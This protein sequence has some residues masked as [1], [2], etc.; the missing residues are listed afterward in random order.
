VLRVFLG[1]V[2]DESDEQLVLIEAD[3]DDMTPAALSAA[4]ERLRAEGARDVS[5]LPLQMKKSR[6]AMRLSVLVDTGLLARLSGAV[7]LHT[8]SIGARYRAVGRSVLAR[9]I[10]VVETVAGPIR[11]K[12]VARP[13]G[14]ESAEPEFEDVAAAAAATGRTFADLREEALAAWRRG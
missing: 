1:T 2:D 8:T 3:I 14:S 6:L 10:E 4:C 12:V 5:V 11:V 13:D 9:R 7:L